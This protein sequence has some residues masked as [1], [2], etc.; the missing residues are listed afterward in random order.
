MV[1][2]WWPVSSS[3]PWCWAAVVVVVDPQSRCNHPAALLL[4]GGGPGLVALAVLVLLAAGSGRPAVAGAVTLAVLVLLLGG[5]PGLVAQLV[6][7]P[8]LDLHLILGLVPVP[9]LILI[10]RLVLQLQALLLDD[11]S[12]LGCR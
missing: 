3:W 8:I 5:G 2:P 1:V 10:A 12:L 11:R 4:L 7:I 6:A 9:G